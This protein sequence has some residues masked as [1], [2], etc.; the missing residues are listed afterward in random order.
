MA[1]TW[2]VDCETQAQVN[3]CGPPGYDARKDAV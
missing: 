3:D 1:C 2:V